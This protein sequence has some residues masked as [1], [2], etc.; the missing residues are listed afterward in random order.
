MPLF[1]ASD[2]VENAVFATL[3]AASNDIWYGTS[4]VSASTLNGIKVPAGT[5]KDFVA[6]QKNI[7]DFAKIYID[8]GTNGAKA[9]V[10]Y[11]V[12]L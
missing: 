5:S 2:V 10:V 12:Q 7:I 8:S 3:Q 9:T 1:T 11:W 4:A 6:D